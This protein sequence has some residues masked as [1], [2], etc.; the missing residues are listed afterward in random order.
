MLKDSVH[1]VW[2]SIRGSS[3]IHLYDHDRYTCKLLL[4]IKTNDFL[5][6]SFIH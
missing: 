5:N 6:V 3:V 2:L 4:D 1:G